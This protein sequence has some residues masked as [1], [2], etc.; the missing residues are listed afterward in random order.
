MPGRHLC[1]RRQLGF[2]HKDAHSR[3]SPELTSFSKISMNPNTS[4]DIGGNPAE[5]HSTF[6]LLTSV[7]LSPKPR[8]GPPMDGDRSSPTEAN[9][10]GDVADHG[11][12]TF[13]KRR[14]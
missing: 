3:T 7:L 10:V 11:L 4:M 13:L 1:D 8:L 6:L 5:N 9:R 2:L 14:S 12:F